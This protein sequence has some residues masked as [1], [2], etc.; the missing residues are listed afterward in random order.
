MQFPSKT[1][2]LRTV[3]AWLAAVAVT[4]LLVSITQT[5]FNLAALQALGADIPLGLRLQTTGQD[6]LGFSPT[7][8]PLAA[9]GLLVA[10]VATRLLRIWLP[11][12]RARLYAL[13]GGVAV[14]TILLALEAAFN[15]TP[16]AA[17]RSLAGLLTLAA[18]GALG[19]WLFARLLPRP[20]NAA[21]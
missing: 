4:T 20:D 21:A 8:G 1:R 6:V 3:A 16:V 10:F 7:F 11:S 2:A 14:L 12:L 18:C 5:Q 17:A 13:A 9:I 15:I 19:G